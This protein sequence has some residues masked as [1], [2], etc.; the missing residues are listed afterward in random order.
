MER[1]KRKRRKAD[2]KQFNT[3]LDR[4]MIEMLQDITEDT[5]IPMNRLIENA[6]REKYMKDEE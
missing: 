4:K 2:R 3:S 6:L 5:G 1:R